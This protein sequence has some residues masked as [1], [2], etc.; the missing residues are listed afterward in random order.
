MKA[1][2]N[3]NVVLVLSLLFFVSCQ[4]EN[5]DDVR[6]DAQAIVTVKDDA[7]KTLSGVNVKMYDEATYAEFEKDNLTKPIL[8]SVTDSKGDATFHLDYDTWFLLRKDRFF[9]FVVQLGGGEVN[10]EI[11]SSGR[12]IQRGEVMKV[13]IKLESHRP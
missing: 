12:T 5:N 8:T 1:T 7:G 13:E 11:W 9:T 6:S 3:F 4:K 10:Y 2:K